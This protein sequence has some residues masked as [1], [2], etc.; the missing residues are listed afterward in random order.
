MFDAFLAFGGLLIMKIALRGFSGHGMPPM[1]FLVSGLIPWMMFAQTYAVCEG[2]IGK[3]KNL[4][5]LPIVTEL[6]LVLASA[7][8]IFATYLVMFLVL[9]VI[10]SFYEDVPFP[11]FALGIAL[12][13]V[14][15]SVMGVALGFF[16]MVLTR[17]YAPAGKF[18]GFFLRFGML[19]SG[20]VFQITSFPTSVWPYLTWNP[21]LH[22]EELLR[23]YWFYTYQSPI[24]SPAFIAECLLGMTFFGLLLERY[25]RR[26]LRP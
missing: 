2:A 11:K 7:L 5:L 4:L 20:V 9:A 24:G 6:D 8:R 15:M 14:S 12:L 21:M 23:S 1:T 13:F 17:L 10:S 26:R 19:F 16:L 22:I 18:T 3:G 25:A